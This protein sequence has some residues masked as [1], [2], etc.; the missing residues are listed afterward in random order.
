M[1]SMA[2]QQIRDDLKSITFDTLRLDCDN[3]FEAVIVKEEM[4]KLT[5]RLES[6]FGSPAWPSSKQ[7]SFQV[8][9]LIEGF[10][11]ITQGQ[12]LYFRDTGDDTV[13]AMLWPWQ[14]GLH[15][16]LKVIKPV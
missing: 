11:G 16:T 13:L 8:R 6:F 4:Q 10:G 5:T 9:Q 2:F 3:R 1:S 7:L 15:T 12:T 14:D